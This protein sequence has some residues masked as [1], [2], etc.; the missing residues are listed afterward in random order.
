MDE[1]KKNTEL[2]EEQLEE[3]SGG[4]GPLPIEGKT[5]IEDELK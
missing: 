4:R 5:I 1:N 3:V 2:N